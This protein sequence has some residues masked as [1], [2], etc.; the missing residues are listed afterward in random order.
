MSLGQ[1]C[2]M[3]PTEHFK[4]G[5]VNGAEWYEVTGGMQDWNYVVAGCMELTLEIGCYKYPKASE[6]PQKWLDNKEALI[7]YIEQVISFLL[8]ERRCLKISFSGAHRATW[9]CLQYHRETD[10]TR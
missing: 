7:K 1:P 3:F 2:P 5:I 8:N 9:I 6:I 10:S 4:G